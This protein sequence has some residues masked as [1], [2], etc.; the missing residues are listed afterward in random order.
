MVFIKSRPIK[1]NIN[2]DHKTRW[3]IAL[4][5]LF[6]PGLI[7]S[8]LTYLQL[9]QGNYYQQR[10]EYSRTRIAPKPSVRGNIYDTKG[11]ILATSG[12]SH[13]VYI[14]P[15]V[16]KQLTWPAT[17]Q[18][19]SSIIGVPPEK[20]SEKLPTN[21]DNTSTLI[22][23]ARNLTPAQITALEEYKDELPGVEVDID[24]VRLYPNQELASHVLGYTGEISEKGLERLKTQGYR[25]GDIVG[26]MGVEKSFE[27][28]LRGESG[29]LMML[30]NG[31]GK[32]VKL[33]GQKQAK[34]GKDIIL[35]LDLDLQ[36]S[37][38]EA[39]KN[40]KGAIVAI[41]PRD[42]S[43][44][45]MASNPNFNPNIFSHPIT[46]SIWQDL[47]KKENPF[48]NRALRGFPPGSTFKIIT[49]TAGMESGKFPP[50]TIL[51]T[52]PY[53]NVS[54]IKFW[55]DNKQGYGS[56]GYVTALSMSSNTFHG[57]IGMSVGQKILGQWARAYGYGQQTGIELS[58]E[59]SAGLVPSE[60]WKQ[61]NY[62]IKWSAGDSVNMSI[63]QGFLQATPLQVAV[64]FSVIAN[65]GYRVIPHLLKNGPFSPPISLH[66]KPSTLETIQ[67][68]LRGVVTQGTGK[69]LNVPYL[70]PMAGKSGT[71]EAPPGPDHTWFGVYAPFDKPEIVVVGFAEHSG[72]YGGTT[73]APLVLKVLETYFHKHPSN[74][75]PSK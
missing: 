5:T 48:L 67:A 59:E 74:P 51:N 19:L 13:D 53:L 60:Q 29:G 71:A 68:G 21:Q 27:A 26:K 9:L 44:L 4:I 41:N 54:G 75:Q 23:V 39:L 31:E 61:K 32:V 3:L 50:N 57:Q 2:K 11:K 40:Y 16:Q 73:A 63:G 64:V 7:I 1:K 66:I 43:V 25:A 24:T 56:I 46:N 18:K 47:Q 28:S 45:A 14:W 38:E 35:T 65:G 52:T 49:Q 34:R 8:R 55:E 72:G 37:A 17:L 30:V 42:G 33:L 20:I 69:I 15:V 62:K 12:L 10:A 6:L 36:K 22:R 70:P 58:N